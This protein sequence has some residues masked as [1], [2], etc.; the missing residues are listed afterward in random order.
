[1]VRME[2]E[3]FETRREGVGELDGDA[4]FTGGVV[5]TATKPR[6]WGSRDPEDFEKLVMIL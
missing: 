3:Q 5:T 2:P 1:M 6:M 4:T